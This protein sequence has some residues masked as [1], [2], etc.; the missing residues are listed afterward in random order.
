MRWGGV[1]RNIIFVNKICF[2]LEV[3]RL[4][5][6]RKCK[7]IVYTNGEGRAI[8]T[9]HLLSCFAEWV[10]KALQISEHFIL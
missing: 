9:E 6:L 3:Y 4:V 2:A 10:L 7:H 1:R 8:V 5:G